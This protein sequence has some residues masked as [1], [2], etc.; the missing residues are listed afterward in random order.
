MDV[1]KIL[2]IDENET[3][4]TPS[5]LKDLKSIKNRLDTKQLSEMS[6]EKAVEYFNKI[7]DLLDKVN[8]W[9]PVGDGGKDV[10]SSPVLNQVNS[11][12]LEYPNGLPIKVILD[13][14]E[15]ALVIYESD[16]KDVANP[17]GMDSADARL[18]L[19]YG[20]SEVDGGNPIPTGVNIIIYDNPSTKL[21][22]SVLYGASAGSYKFN[23]VTV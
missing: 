16:N 14:S 11:K 1:D 9:E 15:N 23:T 4:A 19:I 3:K 22:K 18:T 10:Y 8:K 2:V 13:Q 17:A 7:L 20:K 6:D 5:L 12:E 21:E